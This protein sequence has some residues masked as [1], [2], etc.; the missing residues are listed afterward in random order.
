MSLKDFRTFW[1]ICLIAFIYLIYIH[2]YRIQIM[3]NYQILGEKIPES[4]RNVNEIEFNRRIQIGQREMMKSRIVICGMLRDGENRISSIK[5]RINKLSSYFKD[6]RV[7]IVE[8]DSTDNTRQKLLEWANEN[9][10]IVI[11][12]CGYNNSTCSLK[13]PKTEGH[14]VTW[15][16]I[17]KM[18]YL[19][20]IYL[21]EV[22]KNYSNYDYM[23]VWDMD[24]LGSVYLDGILN[25][26]GYFGSKKFKT[27]AMC[28]NGIY[29]WMV[30]P[31][32]YDT[33]AHRDKGDKFHISKKH[34]HD[35][36]KGITVRYNVGEDP[37]EVDSCFG[38]FT[39]YRINSI[40]NT[41]AQYG[42]T[43]KDSGDVECEHVVFNKFLD[44]VHVNPS[45]I[46]LVLQ[47]E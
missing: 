45:M 44:K 37:V 9:P 7:L 34:I 12:G 39:I 4:F 22:M 1:I 32:Y 33:Y 2:Y 10:K 27:D 20:N 40:L 11:L 31:L 15:N 6:Y 28:A 26:F 38:G 13:L 14:S 5:D 41:H 30:L 18:Q 25:S 19:R 43:S 46:H 16:R 35:I 17:N 47:N 3:F 8:N 29:R 36:D 24:I 23:I 21:E 42:T